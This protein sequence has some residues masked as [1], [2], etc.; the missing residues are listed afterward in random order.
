M[1]LIENLMKQEPLNIK[2]LIFSDSMDR[3]FTHLILSDYDW[4]CYRL[5]AEFPVQDNTVMKAEFEYIGVTEAA[6]YIEMNGK[7]FKKLFN[8]DIFEKHIKKY[9]QKHI[10]SWDEEYAF[11]GEILVIDFFNEV[12]SDTSHSLEKNLK[13]KIS[14]S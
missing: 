5:I 12:L 8:S 10:Q 6:L 13:H 2:D 14:I 11:C 1:Y 9:M 3:A 7:S 4:M